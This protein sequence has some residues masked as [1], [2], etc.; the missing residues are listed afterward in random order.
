MAVPR[1]QAE[2]EVVQDFV[3]QKEFEGICRSGRARPCPTG[4]GKAALRQDGRPSS[5]SKGSILGFC[6]RS[7]ALSAA[8]PAGVHSCSDSRAIMCGTYLLAF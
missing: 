2:F 3:F 1:A 7:V 6:L 5:L 8:L 4:L